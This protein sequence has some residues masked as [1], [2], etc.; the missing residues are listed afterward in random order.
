MDRFHPRH[1]PASHKE[2]R[3][4]ESPRS[5]ALATEGWDNATAVA[6][7]M[8]ATAQVRIVGNTP[9]T[10]TQRSPKSQPSPIS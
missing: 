2:A 8:T 9:E 1:L 5:A 10:K 4:D 7:R 6:M 3:A